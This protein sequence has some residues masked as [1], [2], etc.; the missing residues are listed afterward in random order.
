MKKMSLH[1]LAV[2]S[3]TIGLEERVRQTLIGGASNDTEITAPSRC[4][5]GD[6]FE[7][8]EGCFS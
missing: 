4:G 3:F 2:S 6:P 1:S 7:I 8:T 5:S